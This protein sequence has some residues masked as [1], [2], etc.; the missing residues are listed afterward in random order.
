MVHGEQG[1]AKSTFQE[2]VRMLVAQKLSYT[3]HIPDWISDQYGGALQAVDSL[4][5]RFTQ[6]MMTWLQ[7]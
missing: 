5:E 6:M 1:V 2:L 3:Y 7:L 4:N